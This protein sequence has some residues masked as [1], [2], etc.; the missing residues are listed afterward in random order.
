MQHVM[1]WPRTDDDDRWQ[2]L[3]GSLVEERKGFGITEDNLY[4]DVRNPSASLVHLVVENLLRAMAWFQPDKF[5]QGTVA[6]K[7]TDRAFYVAEKRG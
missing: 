4:R 6:A 5:K 2:E 3:H 7:V 1:I